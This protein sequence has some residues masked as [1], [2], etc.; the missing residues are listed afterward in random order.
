[1]ISRCEMT[2]LEIDWCVDMISFNLQ[3][4]TECLLIEDNF[5]K[6]TSIKNCIN[7]IPMNGEKFQSKE[8]GKYKKSKQFKLHSL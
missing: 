7:S 2:F 6:N 3:F 5:S 4:P 8:E 1:M